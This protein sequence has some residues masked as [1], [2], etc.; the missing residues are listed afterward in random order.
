MSTMLHH[1]KTL[2]PIK[3][4]RFV[5]TFSEGV[6]TPSLKAYQISRDVMRHLKRNKGVY[7]ICCTVENDNYPWPVYVRMT[8][9]NFKHRLDEHKGPKGV[10]KKIEKIRWEHG[11]CQDFLLYVIAADTPAA[12]FLESTFLAAFDFARNKLENGKRRALVR[13][14]ND[15]GIDAG[16]HLGKTLEAKEENL[17]SEINALKSSIW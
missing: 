6:L 13:G 8:S 4:A 11:F 2:G 1:W 9:K 16:R 5:D 10:L 14:G 12:K 17:D 7:F 15:V 3:I